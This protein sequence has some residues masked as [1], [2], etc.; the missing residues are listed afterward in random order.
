MKVSSI[1]SLNHKRKK[2]FQSV[3]N[4]KTKIILLGELMATEIQEL[5]ILTAGVTMYLNYY[6]NT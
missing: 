6:V 3:N 5:I 2:P 4:Y 1:Q